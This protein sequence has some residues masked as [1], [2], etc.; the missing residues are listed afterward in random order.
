MLFHDLRISLTSTPIL[1]CDNI[2]AL[3]LASNLVFHARTKHIEIDYHFIREKI[4]NKDIQA[5]YISTANQVADI[6]TKGLT[7]ARS[8]LR[9][10]K[11]MVRSPP[12]CLKGAVNQESLAKK[13]VS[14]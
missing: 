11:L 5:K 1:W 12:M 4:L 3:A 10:D 6:F 2:G 7:S 13:N 8:L 9:H 14:L